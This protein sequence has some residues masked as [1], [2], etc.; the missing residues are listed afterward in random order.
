MEG[1]G[2]E[3]WGGG[4]GGVDLAGLVDAIGRMFRVQGLEFG[5]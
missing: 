1:G 3:G 2:G 4:G 5:V